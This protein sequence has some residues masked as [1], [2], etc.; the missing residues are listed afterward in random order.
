MNSS[1][2]SQIQ[3]SLQANRE[4]VLRLVAPLRAVQLRIL[5]DDAPIR[6]ADLYDVEFVAEVSAGVDLPT[7]LR[8]AHELEQMLSCR[9]HIH[10]LLVD[11]EDNRIARKDSLPV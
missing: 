3:E 9:V 6:R 5:I 4:E 8:V 7:I 1:S 10:D 11:C 2:F